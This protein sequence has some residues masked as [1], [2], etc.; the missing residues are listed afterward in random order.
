[1]RL[2]Q[3]A[4]F[5]LKNVGRTPACALSIDTEWAIESPDGKLLHSDKER[6]RAGLTIAPADEHH[7][8][9][10]RLPFDAPGQVGKIRT[11]VRYTSAVGGS[12]EIRLSFVQ[13]PA[14]RGGW[15]NGPNRYW[16]QTSDGL[17]YGERDE[18]PDWPEIRSFYD[19][20][21]TA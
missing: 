12:G 16:F 2:E 19:P 13:R 21:P 8:R 14:P 4:Y 5:V 1:M 11:I 10:C 3:D 6:R 20:Q 7:Q 18:L 9:L 15:V 17:Q